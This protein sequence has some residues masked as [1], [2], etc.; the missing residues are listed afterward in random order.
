MASKCEAARSATPPR[1]PGGVTSD[2][3]A[4]V[5]RVTCT[6]PSDVPTQ[7]VRPSSGENA[8]AAIAASGA[9]RVSVGLATVQ[10]WPAVVLFQSRSV[11]K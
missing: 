9:P 2:Q 11:A 7:I 3:P 5:S 4:P 8:S 10:V 6:R 1:A